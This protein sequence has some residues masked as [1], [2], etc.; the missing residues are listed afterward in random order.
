MKTPEDK[1]V[2]YIATVIGAG[3]VIVLIAWV[4][5]GRITAAFAPTVPIA[6]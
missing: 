2:P 6:Y 1:T 4:I 3:I 5:I